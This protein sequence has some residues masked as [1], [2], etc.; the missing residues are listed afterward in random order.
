MAM[1]PLF[2]AASHAS[3]LVPSPLPPYRRPS[4]TSG[5]SRE[6]G[7]H[8]PEPPSAA[9]P[10]SPAA[11]DEW[12][13]EPAPAPPEPEGGDEEAERREE[14]KRCLVDTVYGSDSGSGRPRRSG[15]RS[16]SSLPS[17]RRPIPRP[18]PSRLRTSST[19]TGSSY[20][21]HILSFC[22]F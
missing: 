17:S 11:D 12:G 18:R 9:D 10:P 3:L 2:A 14:L 4:S 1:A 19:A 15:G 22:L 7:T 6:P 5:A 21:Q 8:E 20:I 13:K 16:S